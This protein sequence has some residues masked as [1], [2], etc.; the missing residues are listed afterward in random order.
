M[1]WESMLSE[2]NYKSV[3][4]DRFSKNKLKKFYKQ[5]IFRKLNLNG[6]WNKR[7]TE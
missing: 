4:T 3:N 6:C 2:L 1:E 5:K 7:R